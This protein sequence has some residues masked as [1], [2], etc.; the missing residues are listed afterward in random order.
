MEGFIS[1]IVFI[2]VVI[3]AVRIETGVNNL[4]EALKRIESK[5]D[6]GKKGK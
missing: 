1:F 2:F 4:N 6:N 5:L 3:W